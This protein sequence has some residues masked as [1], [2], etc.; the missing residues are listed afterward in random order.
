MP[1]NSALVA[2]TLFWNVDC[3]GTSKQTKQGVAVREREWIDFK[4]V[5]EISADCVA[6]RC[7]VLPSLIKTFRARHPDVELTLSAMNNAGLKEALIRREIDG[8]IAR[9]AI[10]DDDIRL[11]ERAD[12]T[13]SRSLSGGAYRPIG[14]Q[15]NSGWL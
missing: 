14:R 3:N 2:I 15:A 5:L 4:I 8:A 7:H 12:Q 9:P 13:P 10:E 11:S 6:S 1:S